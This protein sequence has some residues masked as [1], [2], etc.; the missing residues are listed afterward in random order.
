[1][2]RASCEEWIHT[3]KGLLIV[4]SEIAFGLPKSVKL[5]QNGGTTYKDTRALARNVQRACL[6]TDFYSWGSII[7]LKVH[8]KYLVI[9]WQILAANKKTG[10]YLG[11]GIQQ[12]PTTSL[13]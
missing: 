7:H 8:I 6:Y 10:S 1:M 12:E 5:N 13:P 3:P 9:V 2:G 11:V 4:A